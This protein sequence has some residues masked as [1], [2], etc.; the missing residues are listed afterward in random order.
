M[1]PRSL[2]LQL[3]THF[4]LNQAYIC[5]YKLL[6]NQFLNICPLFGEG[7]PNQPS[8]LVLHTEY[9]KTVLLFLLNYS[10]YKFY[11]NCMIQP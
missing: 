5:L 9:Y 3:L 8:V 4:Y 11:E 1:Y 7:F 2:V 6:S 10:R